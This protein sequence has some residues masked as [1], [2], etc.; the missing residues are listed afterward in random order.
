MSFFPT[1]EAM[2]PPCSPTQHYPSGTILP[3]PQDTSGYRKTPPL[4]GN[5]PTQ[6]P[7][8]CL[9][10]LLSHQHN[11]PN[12]SNSSEWDSHCRKAQKDPTVF[13]VR[14]STMAKA[15]TSVVIHEIVT[16]APLYT[17]LQGCR[18]RPQLDNKINFPNKSWL[19]VTLEQTT[20]SFTRKSITKMLD[21]C[22]LPTKE[23]KEARSCV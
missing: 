5:C 2:T 23:Y 10:H 21:G 22:N 17:S 4:I 16:T 20:A 13:P 19:S 18:I 14:K 11:V 15:I 12:T 7:L 3:P 1:P 8:S 9:S 6:L